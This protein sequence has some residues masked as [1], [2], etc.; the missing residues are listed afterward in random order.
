[1]AVV[2]AAVAPFAPGSSPPSLGASVG[3][4]AASACAYPPQYQ[5]SVALSASGLQLRDQIQPME[6]LEGPS[7]H[8][9]VVVF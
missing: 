3:V 8:V 7:L 6:D 1:V 9:V 5:P 2:L 4:P